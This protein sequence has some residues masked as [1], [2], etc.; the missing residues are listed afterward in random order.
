MD[1][2]Q[3]RIAAPRAVSIGQAERSNVKVPT[4]RYYEQIGLLPGLHAPR[5][6]G[7]SMART[8]SA[9]WRSSAMPVSWGSR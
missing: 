7:V 5:A 6:T 1:L 8:I 9:G 3:E 4:I 2:A